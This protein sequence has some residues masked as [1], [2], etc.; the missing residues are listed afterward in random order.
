MKAGFYTIKKIGRLAPPQLFAHTPLLR[1]LAVESVISDTRK[2]IINIFGD[3]H[4]AG[5]KSVLVSISMI[6]QG[7]CGYWRRKWQPTPVSLP[8]KPSGQRSLA[9]Y[10]PWGPRVRYNLVTEQ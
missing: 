4:K 3:R 5:F 9:S 2:F 7:Y 1:L 8:G 6:R 10:G